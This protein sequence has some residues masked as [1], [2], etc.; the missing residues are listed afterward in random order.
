VSEQTTA[1]TSQTARALLGAVAL[2]IDYSNGVQK[3]FAFLPWKPDM[4]VLD[5]LRAA[6]SRKPGLGFEFHVTLVSDRA[7]RA[8]GFMASIDGIQADQTNHK[9]LLWINDHF[10]GH[11]W[12][13]QGQFGPGTGVNNG[14]VVF[15]KLVGGQ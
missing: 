8:R 2:T 14:D 11:E 12:F 6:E 10:F 5:V 13:T 1:G 7:G 9:W 15:L 4:D 3:S